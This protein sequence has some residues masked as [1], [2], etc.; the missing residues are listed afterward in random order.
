M[1]KPVPSGLGPEVDEAFH[2]LYEMVMGELREAL[3]NGEGEPLEP[4]R[5]AAAFAQRLVTLLEERDRIANEE[6]SRG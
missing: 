6:R 2:G 4:A 5:E 3:F 1:G